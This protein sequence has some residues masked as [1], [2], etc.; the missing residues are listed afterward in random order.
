MATADNDRFLRLWFEVNM[1]SIGF[2]AQNKQ[3]CID[4]KRNGS[5]TR[6]VENIE[7]GMETKIILLIGKMMVMK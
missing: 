5:L 2:G 6:K 4:S 3:E 7:N 1:E